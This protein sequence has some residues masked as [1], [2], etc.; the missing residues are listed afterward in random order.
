MRAT[1][2]PAGGTE[3]MIHS[4]RRLLNARCAELRARDDESDELTELQ[5]ALERMEAGTWGSCEHCHRAIGHNRLRALPETRRCVDCA[6][7]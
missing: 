3:N 7:H 6:T 1:H 2:E 5:H 4:A